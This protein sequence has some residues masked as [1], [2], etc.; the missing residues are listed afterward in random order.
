MSVF[1]RLGYNFD[2]TVF[3]SVVN[4]T[5]AQKQFYTGQTN[6]AQWQINDLASSNTSSISSYYQNPMSANLAF[7]STLSTMIMSSAN[8]ISITYL[9]SDSTKFSVANTLMMSANT[10][11]AEIASFIIHTNNL[12][13]VTQS[14]DSANTPDYQI[15]T[16]VGRQVVSILNQTDKL[17]NNTPILGNFTSLTIAPAVA[18]NVIT[19]S[20]DAVTIA[21]PAVSAA[22][23]NTIIGHVQGCY[24][25]LNTRRTADTSFYVNSLALIKDFQTISQLNSTG[26]S[27]DYLIK[28]FIGTPKLLSNTLGIAIPSAAVL[29]TPTVE[30]LIVAGGGGGNSSSGSGGGAGGFR[31]GFAVVPSA[32]I[33][34]VTI[35]AGGAGGQN[36]TGLAGIASSFSTISSVG[37]GGYSSGIAGGSGYGGG[38]SSTAGGA[39][40]PGQGYGGGAGSSTGGYGGGGGGGGASAVGGNCGNGDYTYCGAGGAGRE[41]PIGSGTYYA[42]G[43]GGGAWIQYGGAGG[44][45]GGGAGQAAYLSGY[46]SGTSGSTNTGGGGGGNSGNW[47]AG[48]GGSG[49][50]ILRYADTY[51]T[52]TLVTGSPTITVSGGYRTYKFTSTG[53]IIF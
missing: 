12:S 33:L 38:Y 27:S 22:S 3:G 16:A 20:A 46:G 51:P 45:G 35:G 19:L 17:Q 5:D 21:D 39:G 15:A 11:N 34:A 47:T 48:Y 50:V 49:V 36:T 13:N 40:T 2:S 23:M 37:G 44:Q 24:S 41:W 30:Y 26:V 42:G 52:P 7:I 1:S 9:G 8:T 14:Q 18:A 28:N 53:T 32:S 43:G 25:L 31:T 10:L 29:P 4:F 6:L